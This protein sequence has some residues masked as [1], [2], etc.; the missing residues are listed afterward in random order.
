MYT[1][2]P[3]ERN[4]NNTPDAPRYKQRN[5]KNILY[6]IASATRELFVLRQLRGFFS[7]LFCAESSFSRTCFN[8]WLVEWM[9]PCCSF[10]AQRE[11]C[12]IFLQLA[13]AVWK[14]VY[15]CTSAWWGARGLHW[16][17]KNAIRTQNAADATFLVFQD[18]V[19][20]WPTFVWNWTT[21]KRRIFHCKHTKWLKVRHFYVGKVHNIRKI[22]THD[23]NDSLNAASQT[24]DC[25][26]WHPGR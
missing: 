26:R 23:I 12:A 4:G 3:L 19:S 17:R 13:A 15:R 11:S 21:G 22:N 8:G 5:Y 14:S 1:P 24:A 10:C 18:L 9:I 2:N 7:Q 16:N 6:A 20:A 25:C